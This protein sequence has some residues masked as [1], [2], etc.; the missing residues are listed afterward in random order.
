[1]AVAGVEEEAQEAGQGVEANREVA[2][3]VGLMCLRT[4]AQQVVLGQILYVN[5]SKVL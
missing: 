3:M 2:L 5:G 4:R 1:V